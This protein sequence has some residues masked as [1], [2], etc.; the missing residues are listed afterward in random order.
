MEEALKFAIRAHKGQVR[1]SDKGKP[2]IIHPIN[3]ANILKEYGYDENV[4]KAGYLHDVVEDTEYTIEDI[5]NNFGDDVASLVYNASEPDKKMSW[6]ERKEHTINN[7]KNLDMRH[8]ALI[9]ADKISNLEDLMI[10]SEKNGKYNF[11]AF[12]R[13]FKK[14][15]WYYESIYESL[16][17]NLDPTSPM[18][19][20]LKKLIDHIFNNKRED[21]YIRNVIF[22]GNKKEYEEL[23]K[24]HYKKLEVYKMK[25][26]MNHKPYVIELTGTPRTGKT[27]ILRSLEDF[28]KKANFKVLI[29]EEFTTSK[30][31]KE[32]IYP[33]I[34]NES[35][36]F[37]NRE[38][39]KYVKNSIESAITANPDIIIID[40]G[41]YDRLIWVDRLYQ[42]K[43]ITY[44][45]YDSYKKEYLPLIETMEN[46]VIC[47]YTKPLDA[48]RRDY[49]AN[50]SLEIRSF[51][52]EDNVKEYNNSL[53]NT[54][55]LVTNI[56]MFDTTNKTI[57]EISIG[58][59]NRIVDDMRTKYIEDLNK[60]LN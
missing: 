54:K 16:I 10:L 31:Y 48:I 1:K 51:L 29:I 25:N 5:K 22:K 50:L 44:E 3:V 55:T 2:M 46:Y 15:K 18:F 41:L 7:T 39:P 43:E 12:N 9:C 49:E 23:N 37:R 24:L 19:V 6:E 53:N 34:K 30:K 8:K 42:K 17:H 35:S 36:L 26:V 11:E 21:D 32:E 45:D 4:I 14:Q 52:N 13:G 33:V 47:T 27:T 28:F 20:R 38:I 56:S 60:E 57:K 40:R 59:A 58:I